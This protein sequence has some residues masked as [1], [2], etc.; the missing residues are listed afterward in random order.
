MPDYVSSIQTNL[1][2]GESQTITAQ[3][4]A[5]ISTYN[6]TAESF[7]DNS[8]WWNQYI[9]FDPGIS[10]VSI[11][12]YN[13]YSIG[14]L[15]NNFDTQSP[16]DKSWC[17]I[18]IAPGGTDAQNT[19]HE[20]ALEFSTRRDLCKGD[21]TVTKD[22]I[23]LASGIC[24]PG[25]LPDSDQKIITNNSLA[26]IEY[27]MPTLSEFLG[28][29]ATERNTSE[30]LF[31]TFTTAVAA[32]YW[33]RMTALN[34]YYSWGPN[35][36]LEVT[37]DPYHAQ[38]SEVY[39]H[40]KDNIISTRVTMDPSWILY[41]VLAFQPALAIILFLVALTF[42]Q[43]PMDGGFGMIA[44][45]AGVKKESLRLLEGASL[46]GRLSKPL[47]MQIAVH[48]LVTVTGKS[49]VPEIE[50]ILGGK[51]ENETLANDLKYS[52]RRMGNRFGTIGNVFKRRGDQYEMCSMDSENFHT[53]GYA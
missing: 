49:E 53:G 15:V 42:H 12:L 28:T 19:F 18:G 11:D 33:S 13:N 34:S 1:A 31:P 36:S 25:S 38:R 6:D 40:V 3:V 26:F 21:W 32:M 14:L 23:E 30:W 2:D 20:T 5:T 16:G 22:T 47:R 10:I 29:F 45:L 9:E 4:H 24:T 48:H 52:V 51:G 44:V 8:S 37:D 50:Y 39:Y 41:L 17:F 35:K 43:T 27:Y 46:S 7:R